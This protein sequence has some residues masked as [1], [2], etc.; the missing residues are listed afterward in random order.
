MVH[1]A[2]LPAIC[3]A[4]GGEAEAAFSRAR[5]A[6]SECDPKAMRA[7]NVMMNIYYQHLKRLRKQGW[8]PRELQ[9]MSKPRKAL[10]KAQ[11][12]AIGLRYGLF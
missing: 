4:L 10:H 11:K 6:I 3:E 2:S 5:A 8:N 1:H 12:F 7:P 9:D